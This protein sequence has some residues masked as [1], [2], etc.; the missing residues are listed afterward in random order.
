MGTGPLCSVGMPTYNRP[1]LLREALACITA[2][3]YENLEIIVSDNASSDPDVRAVIDDFARRDSRIRSVVQ[4]R[5]IGGYMNFRF[6]MEAASGPFFL[7]H[8]DDDLRSPDCIAFYMDQIGQSG[9]IFS[10]FEIML[11][12]RDDATFV[13]REPGFVP[14]LSGVP[15]S[16]A[17]LRT[18]LRKRAPHLFYGLFRTEAIRAALPGEA[19][20][21]A[22]S[23]T[24]LRV[25][26]SHGMRTVRSA[27][28]YSHRQIV[29]DFG[30]HVMNG[31]SADP[32]PY[33][34]AAMP[35]VMRAGPLGV[36]HHV[37][38][39]RSGMR[40]RRKMIRSELA[41]KRH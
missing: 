6:V 25:I 27:A 30:V 18:F 31:R 2:Q 20:D 15:G 11:Q 10:D 39:L 1:A 21:W 23:L 29:E 14:A 38:A 33:F 12:S 3:T 22:D 40:L 37:S 24:I 28:L 35:I 13:K 36:R 8:A 19:F 16:R 5:N 4:P 7:W 34:W 17:D 41:I 9:G 26:Q 32:W